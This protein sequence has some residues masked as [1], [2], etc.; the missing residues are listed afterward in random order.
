MKHK[1]ILDIPRFLWKILRIL[2][3]FVNF[4]SFVQIKIKIKKNFNKLSINC[5]D[6]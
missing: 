4:L 2:S 3:C 6:Y 1:R 5:F